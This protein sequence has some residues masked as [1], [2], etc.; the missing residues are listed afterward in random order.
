[1][2]RDKVYLPPFHFNN[3]KLKKLFLLPC[4]LF[5]SSFSTAQT[6]GELWMSMPQDKAPYLT[7]QQKK[8]LIDHYKSGV[9]YELTNK[10]QGTTRVDTLVSDY[11]HFILSNS[12]ELFLVLLPSKE[13]DSIVL[14]IETYKA[15]ELQS[16]PEFY[17]LKWNKLSNQDMLPNIGLDNLIVRPDTMSIADYDNLRSLISPELI[18]YKYNNSSKTLEV[19]LATPLLS[20]EEKDRLKAIFSKLTLKWDGVKFN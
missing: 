3:M 2:W 11:G 4:V 5:V 13:N 7:A 8:E 15:P 19:N 17:D 20:S 1:M 16:K 12:K 18:S 6:V 10:L 9:S 14:C